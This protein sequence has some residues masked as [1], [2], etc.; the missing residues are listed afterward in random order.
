MKNN[1]EIGPGKSLLRVLCVLLGAV[2]L[3][4]TVSLGSAQE[5]KIEK[6]PISYTNPGSGSEMYAKYCAVCHGMTGKGDGPAASE[7]KNPPTDLT[8]LAKHNNGKYPAENVYNTLSFGTS[9]PAHGNINMPIWNS[10][11]WSIDKTDGTTSMRMNNL[12]KYI[13]SIQAK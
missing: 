12:V 9:A 1:R 3:A 7:F 2:G 10:L 4:F 6:V 13:E 5:K 11:F 8:M